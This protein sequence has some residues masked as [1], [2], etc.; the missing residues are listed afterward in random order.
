MADAIEIG[1]GGASLAAL[2][3]SPGSGPRPAV[4]VLHELF[5]LTDFIGDRVDWFAAKGFAA[6]AP[7]LYWRVAPGVSYGYAGEDFDRA[8]ATRSQLDDDQTVADIGACVEYLRS[9]PDCAGPVAVVGYCLGGLLAYLAAAR[10]DIAAAVSFHGVRIETRLEEAG[11]QAAP[12]LLH[13]CGL[14][15]YVPEEAVEQIK[16]AL[17]GRAGVEFHDY[18]DSDHG[19]SRQGQPAFD[20]AASSLAHQR[21]LNFLGRAFDASG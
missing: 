13:F 7:D 15:K 8:F 10:L 3:A 2:A 20:A 9:A 17:T 21:T 12:L 1:I 4:I 5:G 19:F 14:D 16:T 18:P 6:I 11:R